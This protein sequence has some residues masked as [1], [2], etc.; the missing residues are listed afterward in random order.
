MSAIHDDTPAIQR[1]DAA[2]GFLALAFGVAGGAL[3]RGWPSATDP[4]AVGAF[5]AQHRGAVLGQSMCFLASSALYLW[6]LGAVRAVLARA[7]GGQGTVSGV[8]FGAGVAWIVGSMLA[9]SLQIGVALAPTEDLTSLVL[10]VMGTVFAVANL[11]S[12]VMLAAFAVVSLRHGAFPRWLA[13]IALIAGV[14]QLLLWCG[15]VVTQGPLSPSGWLAYVLYPS[16]LVWLVPTA[17]LMV[18]QGRP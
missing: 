15:A 14:A 10:L 4:A 9:Q 18:K 6:F 3:E 12:A 11:P 17:T 16:F 5:L 1:W 2:T 13:A 8:A 7:E